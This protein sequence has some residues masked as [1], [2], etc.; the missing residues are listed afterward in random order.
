MNSLRRVITSGFLIVLAQLFLLETAAIG[1]QP[2]RQLGPGTILVNPT[3][4]Q[5][6]QKP[7]IFTAKNAFGSIQAAIR[8]QPGPVQIYL[9]CGVY[10]DNVVIT[11]SDVRLIGEERAC[12]Q[13][14]PADPSKPVV[15][16]DATNSGS[17]GIHFDEVSDLSIICPADTIC[18]DG[19]KLTGRTDINQPNDYH[20]FSRLAVYGAFQN[21]VNLAGRTIWTDFENME[22][23]YA[24]GNGITIASS[25]VTNALTFRNVR[26]DWNDGYGVYMNNTQVDHAQGI[27]FDTFNAEYNGRYTGLADCAGLYLTGVIQANIENSY[28]EGNCQGNT[29]D[30]RAAEIRITGTYANSVNIIDTAFNLQYGEGGIYNDAFLTTGMY[31]GNKFDTTTN[32]FTMYVATSHAESNVVIGANFNSTPTIIPDGNGW[33]HVRMLSPLGLDYVPVTSVS[34]NSINVGAANGLILY[35]GPYTINN[36]TGGHTGQLL[37]VT[38]CN[39]GVH[40]L[41]NSAGGTGQI[42]FPD[43]LNRTLNVGESLMLYFDGSN[44]RPIESAV[45]TQARYVGTITTTVSPADE[46]SMPGITET[47]HC[48]FAAR[49]QAA[50]SLLGTYL[51]TG[52]GTVTLFHPGRVGAVFDIFCS[53]R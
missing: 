19:L 36:L 39:A 7:S 14:R 34:G 47:A 5:K 13:I 25:G 17:G 44:W 49:N 22:V 29:A 30:N 2:A 8:S 26:T 53:A 4:Q 42:V 32:N 10:T 31:Q 52:S 18:S 27:L 51:T 37:Y 1:Q 16:I 40:V 12:V 33:T 43:G 15:T 41:V 11:T 38:A 28:F 21:G 24:V 6:T 50:A 46:I 35:N 9:T 3:S 45:T 20:K 23:Q 48:L